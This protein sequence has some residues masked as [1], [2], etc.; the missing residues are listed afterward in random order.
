MLARGRAGCRGGDKGLDKH[1]TRHGYSAFGVFLQRL[2]E[3][4]AAFIGG[5]YLF[6]RLAG[7]AM[8]QL[9]QRGGLLG[10]KLKFDIEHVSS[11]LEDCGLLDRD[12]RRRRGPSE[13]LHPG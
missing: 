7:D 12:Y 9:Q 4:G 6:L 5:I 1:K 2:I 8:Q 13:A 10:S 11:L 3:R